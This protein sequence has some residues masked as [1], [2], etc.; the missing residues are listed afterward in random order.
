MKKLLIIFALSLLY[1]LPVQ[2]SVT[3]KEEST[4]QYKLSY[5]VVTAN[6]PEAT[7]AIN[8]DIQGYVNDFLSAMKNGTQEPGLV[9]GQRLHY[10]DGAM[11]YKVC[12]EDDEVLS[13]IFTD[14]RFS[15]GAHGM[16]SDNGL[17]YDK[18]TGVK[19]PL[20][21]YLHITP[22]QLQAESK[23]NLYSLEG[24]SL[25]GIG[26]LGDVTRVPSS[27]YLGGNG[28]VCPIFT[29]YE[30]VPYAYG[31]PCIHISGEKATYYNNLNG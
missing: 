1:I 15:G 9:E 3:S 31:S 23:D 29:L 2:A 12:Y 16:H 26:R 18:N 7:A 27:Y 20:S 11:A 5:P 13:L 21:Y 30:L 24:K 28:M 10:T 6:T 14:Y 25:T 22:D 17:V 8:G 4:A 19:R